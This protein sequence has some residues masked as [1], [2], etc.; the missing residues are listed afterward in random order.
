MDV[1]LLC[2]GAALLLAFTFFTWN[3]TNDF[4]HMCFYIHSVIHL[5]KMQSIA[6][7]TNVQLLINLLSRGVAWCEWAINNVIHLNEFAEQWV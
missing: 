5:A 6:T 3:I 2:Y 4:C 7:L 1:T